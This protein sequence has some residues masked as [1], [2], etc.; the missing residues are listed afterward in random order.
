MVRR[1]SEEGH[2]LL[3]T[4][5]VGQLP[6]DAVGEVVDGDAVA[7]SVPHPGDEV[8]VFTADSH[9]AKFVRATVGEF[10]KEALGR[11]AGGTLAARRARREV[12]GA[13]VGRARGVQDVRRR[14]RTGVEA[15]AQRVLGAVRRA[16]NPM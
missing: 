4:A 10:E 16:V 11:L 8:M 2:G 12:L 15:F 13:Q 14:R 1:R 7:E 5:I 3:A 9:G 6:G